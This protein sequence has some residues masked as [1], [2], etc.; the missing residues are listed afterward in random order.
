MKKRPTK[1]VLVKTTLRV[2]G[3]EAIHAVAAGVNQTQG[4]GQSCAATCTNN[5]TAGLTM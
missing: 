5:D 3:R 1:L 4:Q 2:L